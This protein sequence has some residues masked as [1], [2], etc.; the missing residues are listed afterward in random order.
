[1][2]AI[3]R[4]PPAT[5]LDSPRRWIAPLAIA[6]V[7]LAVFS[8]ALQYGFVLWDD[9]RNFLTNPGYRGLGWAQLPSALT[10]TLLGHRVPVAWLTFSVARAL[11]GMNASGYHLTN[12]VLHAV[13]AVLVYWLARRLL[14]LG[15]AA[16]SPRAITLG[17]FVAALFFAVH[18]LRVESV[19]WLTERRDE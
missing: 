9:D 13:T 18:P 11:W 2:R 1:G 17:A 5:T 4:E 19:V 12:I 6:A 15:L 7:T 3:D 8:P 14:A 10:H 16:A